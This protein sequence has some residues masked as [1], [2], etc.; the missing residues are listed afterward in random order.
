MQEG[1]YDELKNIDGQFK[2]AYEKTECPLIR[3]HK[4]GKDRMKGKF[5]KISSKAG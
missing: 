5:N 2:A 1:T 3:Q 4:E